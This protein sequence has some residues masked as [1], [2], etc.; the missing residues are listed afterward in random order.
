MQRQ[1]LHK[2]TDGITGKD[3]V[4]PKLPYLWTSLVLFLALP[5]LISFTDTLEEK[6]RRPFSSFAIALCFGS[7]HYLLDP[8]SSGYGLT[9]V[10]IPKDW[11]QTSWLPANHLICFAVPTVLFGSSVQHLLKCG[12]RPYPI[13]CPQQRQYKLT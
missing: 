3:R 10:I 5:A 13:R 2:P 11:L 4:E 8:F 12:Y 7:C 6:K 1:K 9:I